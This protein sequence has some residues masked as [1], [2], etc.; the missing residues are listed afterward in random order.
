M[1]KGVDTAQ[2]APDCTEVCHDE[3]LNGPVHKI[4]SQRGVIVLALYVSSSAYEG[5]NACL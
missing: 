3:L 2:F 4:K 5:M 1:Q